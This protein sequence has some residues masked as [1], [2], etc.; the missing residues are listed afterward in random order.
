MYMYMYVPPEPQS[1]LSSSK[2]R[3]STPTLATLVPEPMLALPQ[4]HPFSSLPPYFSVISVV[5]IKCILREIIAL[6]LVLRLI[7]I[8]Q[9]VYP[10]K[11]RKAF[12]C[13]GPELRYY[14]T[15]PKQET[16]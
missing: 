11:D 1:S 13:L 7:A 10:L 15:N 2:L 8:F 16:K 9:G 12:P 14:G 6:A 4:V 5:Y 3:A